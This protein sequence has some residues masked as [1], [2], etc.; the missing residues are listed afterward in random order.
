M[1]PGKLSLSRKGFDSSYGG[2]PSPIFPD[3]AIYPLPIPGDDH[4]AVHHGDLDH[5]NINTGQVVE[6][7][8][9]GRLDA[10]DGFH[11]D[12]DVR[13]TP[14]SGRMPS[15]GTTDGGAYSDRPALRRGIWRSRAWGPGMCSC[16]SPTWST[17]AIWR[18]S[19]WTGARSAGKRS[20]ERHITRA[21]PGRPR[22]RPNQGAERFEEG[23]R[24]G[25]A[26]GAAKLG[27]DRLASS[28]GFHRFTDHVHRAEG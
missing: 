21:S 7:L 4:A 25:L 23:R 12:P 11:L 26:E 9:R 20:P 18:S 10:G 6:D 16:S 15:G 1:K 2:C 3:G 14:M 8:T 13:W 27:W 22:C 19:S 24:A 28:P 5:G 17:P